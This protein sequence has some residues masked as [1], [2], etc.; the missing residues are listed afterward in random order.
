MVIAKRESGDVTTILDLHA[1]Q[2]STVTPFPGQ[3]P[4]PRSPS[5]PR[6]PDAV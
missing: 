1:K 6:G 2:T 3:K 4:A 5:P